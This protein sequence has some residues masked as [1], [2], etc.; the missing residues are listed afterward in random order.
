[1]WFAVGLARKYA[2]GLK[3]VTS[4]RIRLSPIR[5]PNSVI[6]VTV[7]ELS[8]VKRSAKGQAGSRSP[9]PEPH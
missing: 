9:G 4:R 8:A 2:I 6:P 3:A 1:V 7:C 5:G